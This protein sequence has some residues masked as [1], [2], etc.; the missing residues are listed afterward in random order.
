MNM[1][2]KKFRK[3]KAIDITNIIKKE[4]QKYNTKK[5]LKLNHLLNLRI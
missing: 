5:F 1:K 4:S 3:L 2:H